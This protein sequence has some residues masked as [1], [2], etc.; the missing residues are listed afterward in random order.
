[1]ETKECIIC[2]TKQNETLYALNEVKV[3]RC[4]DCGLV[5]N[6]LFLTDHHKRSIYDDFGSE[7]ELPVYETLAEVYRVQFETYI[8]LIEEFTTPGRLL[9][10]G[11]AVGYFLKVARARGWQA[12]GIDISAPAVAYARDTFGL[13][14]Q[15]TTLREACFPD[16]LFDVITMWDTIEHLDDPLQELLEVNRISENEGILVIKTPN[17]NGL[18][19]RGARFVYL[20]SG[21]LVKFHLSFLYYPAHLYSFSEQTLTVL[22]K[23]AGYEVLAVRAEMSDRLIISERIRRSQRGLRRMLLLKL[24]LPIVFYLA[25]ITGMPNKQIVV[26]RKTSE[27]DR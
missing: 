22:L 14:V 24:I 8:S 2:G 4:S 10:I 1:M 17:E 9:D 11:C 18:F 13:P 26:A 15:Q 3:V 23:K 16:K 6:D 7:F 19:K 5:F 25:H 12:R 20:L 27:V 21:G